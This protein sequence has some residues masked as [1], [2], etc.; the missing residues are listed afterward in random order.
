[1]MKNGTKKL[2]STFQIVRFPND[3]CVGSNTRN[4]TCYTSAECSDKDGTS[5]GSCADGFG[6]CCTFLITK[7]GTSSSENNTYWTNPTSTSG[8][9]ACTLTVCP[10]SDDICRLR[11]DF[12]LFA[13]T[14][15][16][17]I[18]TT[19]VRRRLGVPGG[20]GIL[21]DGDG[22]TGTSSYKTNCF[23]DTFSVTG[24]SPSATPPTICGT[25][26]GMH[27]YVDADA[28]R[29]N[30][31]MFTFA[32][33][34]TSV[35]TM[36]NSR[37]LA[38]V[39]ESRTWD[40]NVSQIECTSLVLPPAGC[41]EYFWGSGTYTL[42]SY[43]YKGVTDAAGDGI[44]TAFTGTHLANQHQ[45][46]CM[47]RERGMC[48]GCYAT[49]ATGLNVS[50]KLLASVYTV[51]GGCC[52]Y[53]TELALGLLGTAQANIDNQGMAAAAM[54]QYG[55]DCIIIP[56]AQGPATVG[57]TLGTPDNTA[58]TASELSQTLSASPNLLLQP[59]P[60]PPQICG[61]GMGLGIG[62]TTLSLAAIQDTDGVLI[63]AAATSNI[64]IC[65][66]NAP[67]RLEFMSDDLEGLG[68]TVDNSENT[69][70]FGAGNQGF[71]ISHAQIAC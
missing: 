15:P 46:L 16:S 45:R 34:A 60:F 41:T 43:N 48:L 7:C 12:T 13:I 18:S 39:T 33:G 69:N 5:S 20:S 40:I 63:A 6:V 62:S 17:T 50:G 38:S 54:T 14:G 11:L 29:C 28:D 27:M 44:T 2:I 53:A 57:A 49:D 37:G 3:V 30:K 35:V 70:A 24:A 8:Q 36:T 56:G 61:N 59:L 9:S 22:V 23:L 52:G 64:T 42:Q 66:R 58:Q 65:T 25:N 1:M 26:T 10:T 21:L 19:Q 31:L 68:S 51:A 4:G 71:S 47:R 67:F 55:W 32:D